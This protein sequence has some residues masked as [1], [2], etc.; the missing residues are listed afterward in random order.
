LFVPK[1]TR[2]ADAWTHV[3]LISS[4]ES[5]GRQKRSGRDAVGLWCTACERVVHHGWTSGETNPVKRHCNEKRHLAILAAK[6]ASSVS[7]TSIMTGVGRA[8]DGD[9]GAG[10]RGN[11]TAGISGWGEDFREEC[12]EAPHSAIDGSRIGPK[13]VRSLDH[14]ESLP[15]AAV[16]SSSPKGAPS[17][18]AKLRNAIQGYSVALVRSLHFSK[19]A[20]I[21]YV[22]TDLHNTTRTKT[23]PLRSSTNSSSSLTDPIVLPSNPNEAMDSAILTPDWSTMRIPPYSPDTAVV[24]GNLSYPDCPVDLCCRSLLQKA[25]EQCA[26]AR[27]S[28]LASVE[29]TVGVRL[30]AGSGIPSESVLSPVDSLMAMLL[31]QLQQQEIGV[32]SILGATESLQLE[33]SLHESAVSLVDDVVIIRENMLHLARQHGLALDFGPP[34]E[35]HFHLSLVDSETGQNL[36]LRNSHR[37]KFV[38]RHDISGHGRSFLE[39]VLNHLPGLLALTV[40]VE[41][42]RPAYSAWDMEGSSCKSPLRVTFQGLDYQPCSWSANL[43]LALAGI[44][45]TG[46]NGMA[47]GLALRPP[48]SA[49]ATTTMTTSGMGDDGS[50]NSSQSSP[51]NG[52]SGAAS[53]TA[54]PLSLV[55]SFRALELDELLTSS[56]PPALLERYTAIHCDRKSNDGERNIVSV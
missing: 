42:S 29:L 38:S 45:T 26:S 22:A 35:V 4:V 46:L 48:A 20:M 12:Q 30:A 28:V 49:L 14:S 18:D 1:G 9:G 25:V 16:S 17:P 55:E 27:V 31:G 36:L 13:D 11:D 44:L 10:Q 3:R 37:H 56:L 7:A 53:A 2:H 19:V 8:Q 52:A 51:A 6:G 43:Y 54:M 24:L 47:K 39:G 15:A 50:R 32:D 33:L 21:K 40:P 34:H 5:A 23:I 41:G